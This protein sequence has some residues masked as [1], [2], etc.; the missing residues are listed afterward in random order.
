MVDYAAKVRVLSD[1]SGSILSILSL[2]FASFIFFLSSG[3]LFVLGVDLST[4]KMSLNP[5]CEIAVEEAIRLKEKKIAS[6]V[7]AGVILLLCL[8]KRFRHLFH[9]YIALHTVTVGPKSSQ[10]VLRTALAMGADRAIHVHSDLRLD[11]ELQP[12][13]VARAFEELVKKEGGYS[14]NH[15]ILYRH[16]SEQFFVLLQLINECR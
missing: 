11:Q 9:V 16:N 4:V 12:T 14:M 5:F 3:P 13:A 6:E 7:V 8:H 1:K 15:P 10:E 2:R